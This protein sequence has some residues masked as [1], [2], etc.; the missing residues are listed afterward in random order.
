MGVDAVRRARDEGA[1][2]LPFFDC[3]CGQVVRL[4]NQDLIHFIGHHFVQHADHKLIPCHQLI[5]IGKEL[6]AGKAAMPR[7]NAV[8]AFPPYRQAGPVQMPNGDLKHLVL[9]A[10][11]DG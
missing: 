4:D 5:Q 7:Q 11:I 2:I 6:R 10:M 8:G 3:Q 1:Q 9:R